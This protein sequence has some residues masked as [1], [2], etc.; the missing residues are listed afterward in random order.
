MRRTFIPVVVVLALGSA[1]PAQT[2]GWH[3]R[4]DKG[5][6]LPARGT[7]AVRLAAVQ[8]TAD[9]RGGQHPNYTLG[10]YDAPSLKPAEHELEVWLDENEFM[11]CDVA[12]LAPVALYNRKGRAM[13]FTG[14]GIAVD[15][16][17]VEGPLNPVWPPVSHR[18]LFGELP[19][20]ELGRE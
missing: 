16:M 7:E 5:Q 15:W 8:L 2:A 4:W 20:V 14:P 18:V 3:F 13:G 12:S 17:D 11:G 1:A 19:I 9:G 6:V 10:Y